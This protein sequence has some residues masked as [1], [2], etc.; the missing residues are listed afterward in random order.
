[1]DAT[2][3]TIPTPAPSQT[4]NPRRNRILVVDPALVARQK[5]ILS[6][7]E[8]KRKTNAIVLQPAEQRNVIFLGRTRSGKSTTLRMLKD[9]FNFAQAISLFSETKD[10]A[11][12]S[13]TMSY[14]N[15]QKEVINYNINII[16]TPG[17]FERV[18]D[19]SKER[20]NEMIKSTISKCLEFEITKVHAVFFVCSF[21]TGIHKD[22]IESILEMNELFKGADK[23]FSLL[24]TH[25]EKKSVAAQANLEDQI[26]QIPQLQEFFANQNV[27]VF[28]TGALDP[29]D[30]NNGVNQSV[31]VNLLNVLTL[32]K[33]LYT[34][35]FE[36]SEACHITKL[37]VFEEQKITKDQLRTQV[38]EL[39]TQLKLYKGSEDQRKSLKAQ[40]ADRTKQLR[41]VAAQLS[42]VTGQQE[43]KDDEELI[44]NADRLASL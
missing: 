3:S 43:I 18:V 15:E 44:M 34:H 41:T 31:E 19:R 42:R 25:C 39:S 13:F 5:Q 7:L 16:D 30:Y 2:P 17:L 21:E 4:S 22:D 24:V 20:N 6:L 37:K 27:E 12:Y 38:E 10:P 26:R 36:A 40:L 11:L 8:E 14:T 33:E 23:A 1:L 28:F 35:I 32:R 29:D 9:P